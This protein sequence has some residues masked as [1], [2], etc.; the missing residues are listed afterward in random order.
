MVTRTIDNIG[1]PL[2][3]P[4]GIILQNVKVSFTLVKGK[5][6]CQ[7]FDKFSGECIA[8]LPV[9]VYT[10][11]NG[12]F[13]VDLWCTSRGFDSVQYVCVVDCDEI[14]N[15]KAPL[16]EGLPMTWNEFVISGTKI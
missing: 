14:D 4:M 13:R 9:D 11:I 10:D 7:T 2:T 5:I 8:P 15:F 3:S 16:P 1:Q 6:P 12:E